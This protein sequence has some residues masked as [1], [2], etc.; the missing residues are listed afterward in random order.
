VL[1]RRQSPQS[2]NCTT[3]PALGFPTGFA[4]CPEGVP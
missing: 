1:P 3:E 2:A 4:D